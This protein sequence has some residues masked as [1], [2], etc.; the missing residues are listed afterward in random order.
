M[1]TSVVIA[2][3]YPLV[4]RGVR[5]LLASREG[6]EVVGEAG[7]GREAVATACRHKPAI[8]LMEPAMPELNDP[9]ATARIRRECPRTVVLALSSHSEE[10]YVCRMLAAGAAGYLLKT[11]EPDEL[12]RA[13]GVA[14]DG[15]TYLTPRVA[16]EI[17]DGYVHGR[18]PEQ[19]G[20]SELSD[21]EREVL[22]LMAEGKSAKEIGRLLRVSSRTIDS[23]RQLPGCRLVVGSACPVTSSLLAGQSNRFGPTPSYPRAAP[24]CRA[25]P[26][27]P[28]IASASSSMRIREARIAKS[29]TE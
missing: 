28:A 8:V 26:G 6:F 27:L 25:R 13:I 17:V 22:Q 9:D 12:V 1:S 5:S 16:S 18:V 20:D 29:R 2:D 7:N 23:H 24:S 15:G 14:L 21:R 19:S 11:C 3:D 10:Q 4:R